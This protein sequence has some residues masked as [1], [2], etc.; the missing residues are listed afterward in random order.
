MLCGFF[1]LTKLPV[2]S[3]IW[4]YVDSLSINQANA[5]IK[6]MSTLRERVWQLC[7]FEYYRIRISVDTTVETIF[8]NQQGGRCLLYTS[9]AADE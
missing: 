8:G 1:R 5:F 9:D 4:R 6:I 7:E 2:A 3:T